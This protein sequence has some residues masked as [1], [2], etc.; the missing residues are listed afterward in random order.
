MIIEEQFKK[1]FKIKI[2]IYKNRCWDL[3]YIYSTTMS[4][5]LRLSHIA[6]LFFQTHKEN[7]KNSFDDS[8]K[9]SRL[10]HSDKHKI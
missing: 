8:R 5:E 2:K 6:S 7:I 3:N 10:N 1:L 4:Q 9:L